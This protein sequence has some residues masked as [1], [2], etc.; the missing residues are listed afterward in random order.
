MSTFIEE[1]E[2]PNDIEKNV[3]VHIEDEASKDAEVVVDT[4]VKG[5]TDSNIVIDEATNRRL[6][7]MIN[8]RSLYS[9]FD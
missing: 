7:R 1:H 3:D 5:Y 9:I 2:E 8:T 4:D 6:L